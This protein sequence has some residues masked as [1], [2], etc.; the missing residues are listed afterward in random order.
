MVIKIDKFHN[1]FCRP[2][3]H[4]F[5]IICSRCRNLTD[6]QKTL[7]ISKQKHECL[8]CCKIYEKSMQTKISIK[9][10]TDEANFFG[11]QINPLRYIYERNSN[12]FACFLK[13]T[14]FICNSSFATRKTLWI[15]F[16]NFIFDFLCFVWFCMI[17]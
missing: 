4:K 15:P 11:Q 17:V 13:W 7:S 3:Q 16:D 14:F 2:I 10:K 9:R 5:R 1:V 12:I 6:S 8:F